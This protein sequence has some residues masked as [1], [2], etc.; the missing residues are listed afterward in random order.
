MDERNQYLRLDEGVEDDNYGKC[1][2][3]PRG[4]AAAWCEC[5][6][7]QTACSLVC[8][9]GQPPPDLNKVDPVYGES[10]ERF[11]FEYSMLSAEECPN[12]VTLL[13]FD[14][15][16]FCCNEDPPENCSVCPDGQPLIDP[17]KSVR[18]ELYGNAT[19]GEIETYASY[20]PDGMCAAFINE[21][22]DNPF[23]ASGECCEGGPPDN[24][25]ATQG[26]AVFTCVFMLVFMISIFFK[27]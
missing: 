12:A 11:M 23:G 24:S 3:T 22:L 20:L 21:L 5:D 16:A 7:V 25:G 14:A 4:R 15:K 19:C 18:T 13:N 17:S 2:K 27:Y 26:K 10:C 9:D 6:G 1:E 8:G